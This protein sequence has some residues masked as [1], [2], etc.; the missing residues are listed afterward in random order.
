MLWLG[1]DLVY[2]CFAIWLALFS[3]SR[4][5]FLMLGVI[6]LLLT[7]AA[8]RLSRWAFAGCPWLLAVP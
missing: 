5:L 3:I 1:P 7:F 8:G 4:L 6:G 2:L